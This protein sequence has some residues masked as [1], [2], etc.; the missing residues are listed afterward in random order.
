MDRYDRHI[1]GFSVET[2]TSG[3]LTSLMCDAAVMTVLSDRI[4]KLEDKI[5]N[6]EKDNKDLRKLLKEVKDMVMYA[7]AGEKYLEAKQHFEDMQKQFVIVEKDEE[8][9]EENNESTKI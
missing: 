7:P 1:S 6:L 5:D 2:Y 8:N 4:K 3:V 9:N